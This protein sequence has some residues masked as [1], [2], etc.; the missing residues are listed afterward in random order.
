M[1]RSEDDLIK[2]LD[3]DFQA[4]AESLRHI[5]INVTSKVRGRA[6]HTY[7]VGARGIARMCVPLGFPGNDFFKPG[8]VFPIILRH[9]SPGGQEDDRTRDGAGA[10]LKFY[11]SI[12]DP[13]QRGFHDI[14]MNTGRVLFVRSARAVLSMVTTPENERVEKLL[15][16]GILHD[17][18]LAEGYRNGGSFTDFYY[19]SQICYEFTD[20]DGVMHYLRYRLINGDRGPERG[21]YP[22]TWKPNG[23]SWYPPWEDDYRPSNFKRQDFITRVK[24]GG[25]HY[26][27]QG[28]L[29]SG[30][31]AEAVN[32]TAVWDPQRY[33]WTD[34]AELFLNEV[35]TL[36][37]LDDLEFDANRT[38]DCV[39]L[40]LATTKRWEGLQADNHASLGHV[41][42]LVYSSARKARAS[43]PQPHAN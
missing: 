25:L 26:L 18:N 35:L 41:R 43:A 14:M 30:S 3:S 20:S 28:Q 21:F 32:C 38:H 23:V 8:K 7:G 16:T 42:A 40:P 13:K 31:D 5:F 10:A 37:D 12:A 19:H 24:H 29:R 9:S 15:K 33:P 22:Q 17:D 2:G 27:L 36:E 6:S 39:A 34:L 1:S 4:V 11:D